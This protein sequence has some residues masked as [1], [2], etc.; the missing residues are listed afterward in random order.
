CWSEATPLGFQPWWRWRRRSWSPASS[1]SGWRRGGCVPR[2]ATDRRR[3]RLLTA[4]AF[5]AL[6]VVTLVLGH[7]FSTGQRVDA[8][9][10]VTA[11]V[12]TVMAFS[13]GAPGRRYDGLPLATGRVIAVIPAFNENPRALFRTI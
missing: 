5:G 13:V 2:H 6:A 8:T 4:G 7:R 11:V 1:P 3:V 9:V 10:A 12:L